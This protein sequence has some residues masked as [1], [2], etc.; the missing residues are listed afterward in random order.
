[1]K[2][3]NKK[4]KK[5]VKAILMAAL[6]IISWQSRAE[7]SSP[8]QAQN[9][10]LIAEILSNTEEFST[11]ILDTAKQILTI[12]D[13]DRP[14][15]TQQ[16]VA[17]LRPEP[18]T[19][20]MEKRMLMKREYKKLD[21]P[22]PL[23]ALNQEPAPEDSL[24]A[25]PDESNALPKSPKE[26]KPSPVL[27]KD[28]YI[29][30][31]V[32][33]PGHG[34]KD[35]G[36]I[37]PNGLREKDVNLD[38]AL[39]LKRLLI[40]SGYQVVMTRSGD[41]FVSLPKRANIANQSDADLMLSIHSNASDNPEAQGVSVYVAHWD[42]DSLLGHNSQLLAKVMLKRIVAKVGRPNRGMHKEGF[43]V[44]KY[45][46]IP[47]MLVECSFISNDYEK[48][49]LANPDYRQAIAESLFLAIDSIRSSHD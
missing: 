32:L 19:A 30:R 25:E 6:L 21:G 35:P 17:P 41:Y 34:G 28:R 12:Y 8:P 15:V 47:A 48:W 7:E 16:D 43:Y 36:A 3:F 5:G 1:M 23:P 46:Q 42:E 20:P 9:Q 31:I 22:L 2:I 18:A 49:L 33:D 44:L 4:V 38:V 40:N 11:L 14:K 29:Q 37:G 45:S 10:G 13:A 24:S 26:Q 39:K 27:K